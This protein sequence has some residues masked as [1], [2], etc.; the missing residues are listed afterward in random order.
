M[1]LIKRFRE[2]ADLAELLCDTC[3]VR[4]FRNSGNL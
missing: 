1:E 4:F 3:D 2:N